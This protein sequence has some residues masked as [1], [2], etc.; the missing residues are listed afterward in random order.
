MVRASVH[1]S[2]Q[3]I[4]MCI[5]RFHTDMYGHVMGHR[6]TQ[7]DWIMHGFEVLK[8]EGHEGLKADRMVKALNVSRG[9]F[10][11]HFKSIDDF[12][13]ALLLAWRERITEATIA[14]LRTFS[15]GEDQLVELIGR[16]IRTPQRLEAAMRAWGQVDAKITAAVSAVDE[17]RI[18]YIAGVLTDEGVPAPIAHGRAVMLAWAYIGRAFSPQFV[19]TL[20]GAIHHD[21]GRIFSTRHTQKNQE[22]Q[23]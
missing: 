12:H 5:V 15:G 16:V 10:Y 2:A 13:A 7:T 3:T 6:L 23:E 9:S 18:N 19:E 22:E 8:H 20:D 14:D 11:W 4:Q 17:V 1:L 21:L